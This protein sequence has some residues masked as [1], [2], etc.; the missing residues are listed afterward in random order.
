MCDERLKYKGT[1]GG[2]AALTLQILP[3]VVLPDKSR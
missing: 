1:A 2:W 3:V